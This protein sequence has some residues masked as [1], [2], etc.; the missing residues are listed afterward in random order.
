MKV[1][2]EKIDNHKVVLEVE[3]PS[4]E[5]KKAYNKAYV[6][7]AGKINVPGFRKGKAPRHILE[8][9]YGKEI[10]NEEVFDIVVPPAYS[11]ALKEQNIIPVTRPEID[12]V[13]LADGEPMVFKA[14]VVARP[15]VELGEYKGLTVAAPKIEV[16]EEDVNKNLDAMRERHAQLVVVEDAEI[17]KGD[18]A[19]IDFEGFVDG[20]PFKGGD[21]KGYPLEVGSGSFIPGFEDQLMGAKAGETRTVKVT[22]PEDYF[23]PELAG[24]NAEFNVVIHDIKR[25]S[26]PELNDDFAKEAGKFDSVEELKNDVKN[27]LE[28]AAKDRAERNFKNAVIKAAVDNAKVDIP[29]VMV[30][31]RITSMI[32]DLNVSLESRG[33]KLE[34]YLGYINKTIEELRNEYREA[35][36]EG[37]KTDLVLE[38]IAKQEK[39]EVEEKDLELE[40][41]RMAAGYNASVKEVRQIIEEQGH[42]AALAEN[43]LRSKAAKIVLDSAV[44]E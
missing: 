36:R 20:K 7:L 5:I 10:F 3:I 27:K 18:Y 14:T 35:A 42:W 21:A 11:A 31:D 15:E 16:T 4:E 19:I 1:T 24:K 29:E 38:A 23:V 6:R 33:M 17:T 2:A 40:L 37:V 22:F 39:L 25:K 26:V 34:Q 30:D 28:E 8:M 43:A 41:V 9:R 32:A 44:K 12:L 13:K